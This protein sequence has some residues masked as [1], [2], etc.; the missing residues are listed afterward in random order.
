[1]A[2]YPFEPAVEPTDRPVFV[3]GAFHKVVPS[4]RELR[5]GAFVRRRRLHRANEDRYAAVSRDA[6]FLVRRRSKRA[7]GDQRPAHDQG[8]PDEWTCDNNRD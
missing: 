4:A 5:L 1:M 6:A 8:A 7:L 2:V 3:G